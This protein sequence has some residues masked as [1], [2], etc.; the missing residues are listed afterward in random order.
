MEYLG[1][2]AYFGCELN[3]P[4]RPKA[5]AV[6]VRTPGGRYNIKRGKEVWAVVA[7]E[8]FFNNVKELKIKRKDLKKDYTELDKIKGWTNPAIPQDEQSLPKAKKV[9]FAEKS[10]ARRQPHNETKVLRRS[11]RQGKE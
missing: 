4:D 11:A 2:F 8:E 9:K 5:V 1:Y 10:V 6:V 3:R 7:K